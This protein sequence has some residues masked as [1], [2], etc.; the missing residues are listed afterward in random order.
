L[1]PSPPLVLNQ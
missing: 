1:P